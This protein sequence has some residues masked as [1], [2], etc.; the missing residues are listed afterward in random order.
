[1]TPYETF[2]TLFVGLDIETAKTF[3]L[4][5]AAKNIDYH[6]RKDSNNWSILVKSPQAQNA[7]EQIGIY[8]KENPKQTNHF[9]L[10][11]SEPEQ[12]YSMLWIAM[13]LIAI[14]LT[15]GT[16]GRKHFFIEHL[17]ALSEGILEGE[18]FRCATALTLHSDAAHLTAN[19]AGIALFGT[20]LCRTVGTG[21]GWLLILI[22]GSGGNFLNAVFHQA[23]HLSI[24]ASTSVFSTL[25]S[26][27][28]I[29]LLR[30]LGMSDRKLKAFLPLGGGLAIL[31]L[32]GANPTT[33]VLAHLFGFLVGFLSAIFWIRVFPQKLNNRIQWTLAT[34]STGILSTAFIIGLY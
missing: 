17:G 24:G 13:V 6:C 25:G 20:V 23:D 5:L 7:R 29:A 28:A 9:N 15:A 11:G 21:A 31:A 4:V 2:D 18:F 32:L 19:L 34:L 27:S 3:S 8:L 1:M 26:L 16:G 10:K 14:H 33:D 30:Q 22:G 12:N